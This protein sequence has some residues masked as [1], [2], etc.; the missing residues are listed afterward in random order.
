[1]EIHP[2]VAKGN[3]SLIV[4]HSVMEI[5]PYDRWLIIFGSDFGSC[6]GAIVSEL[7]LQI[8]L[9]DIVTHCDL[10]YIFPTVTIMS[11]IFSHLTPSGLE[12][13][14]VATEPPSW[15]I[16]WCTPLHQACVSLRLCLYS[17]CY[18]ECAIETDAQSTHTMLHGSLTRFTSRPC[19]CLRI[20]LAWP[21]EGC[22][23]HHPGT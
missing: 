7:S 5:H 13:V 3:S 2:Y 21:S 12:L 20:G 11:I 9:G 10:V 22:G 4:R 8:F 1:M 16:N 19:L 23:L 17:M 6:Q 15:D 14:S 18:S